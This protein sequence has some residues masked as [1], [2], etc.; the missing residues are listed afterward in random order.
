MILIAGIEGFLGSRLAQTIQ[1]RG[2]KVYGTINQS[3]PKE[4]REGIIYLNHKQTNLD[5]EI[6]EFDVV[7]NAV[8]YYGK[9]NSIYDL[10]K[11]ITSNSASTLDLLKFITKQ[12]KTVINLSSYFEFAP[13]PPGTTLS[14]YSASKILGRSTLE[15]F[16]K[17]A[18]VKFVSCVLYDNYSE[19][20]RRGKLI[21]QLVTAANQGTRIRINNFN[22]KMNLI[23]VNDLVEIIADIS[24]YEHKSLNSIFQIKS[25]QVFS[26]REIINLINSISVNQL[27]VESR[28]KNSS[29]Y[30]IHEVWNS[31]P[32][33]IGPAKLKN[34]EDFL[35][36]GVLT[37][38]SN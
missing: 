22:N 7:I 2:F 6:P 25:G 27:I 31:A 18:E 10:S 38:K 35:T 28:E 29:V 34:F 9:T 13:N 1:S 12:T 15:N 21:D 20:L 23:Y 37:G 4:P 32:D 36:G 17:N 19:D 8:G 26:V 24:E 30:S 14:Q 5:L 3:E 11:N 16:C 33:W